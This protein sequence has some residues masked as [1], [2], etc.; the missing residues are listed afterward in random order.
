MHQCR[1]A[2]FVYAKGTSLQVKSIDKKCLF[3]T[4]S[5]CYARLTLQF[6]W[7]QAFFFFISYSALCF[8]MGVHFFWLY[9]TK[10][11]TQTQWI[12]YGKH[13]NNCLSIWVSR[14]VGWLVVFGLTDPLRQ[15]FSLYRVVSQGRKRRERIDESKIVQTTPTRTYCKSS[16]PLPY[17]IQTSR[18]PRHWKFIQDHR[19][20]RPPPSR[21]VI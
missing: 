5:Y 19:T 17:S 20:T 12:C 10:L 16:R 7:V 9:P 4:H 18:T 3:F 21:V 13:L 6:R 14:V 11:I 15:Y 2:Q 1:I 8:N